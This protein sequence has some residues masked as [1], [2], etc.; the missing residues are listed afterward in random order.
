M[1]FTRV[2]ILIAVVALAADA[3]ATDDL[4]QNGNFESRDASRPELPAHWTEHHHQQR[5]LTFTDQ[6]YSPAA[7][8][9][10]VGDGTAQMWRQDVVK[11]PVRSFTLSGVVKAEDVIIGKDDYAH[12][13]AHII[14]EGRPYSDATHFFVETP[15]GT[16]D[17]KTISVAGAANHDWPIDRIHISVQGK[18]TRGRIA[19]DDVKLTPNRSLSPEGLLT[20]KLA[21]LKAQLAR[22]GGVDSSVA[23][24]QAEVEK[25]LALLIGDTP[26][27]A[28]AR[29]HWIRAAEAV[30]PAAWAAVYPDAMTER[31]VEARMMYHG[32][33]STPEGCDAYLDLIEKTGCNAAYLSLGSW[34]YVNYPSEVF[35]T[36]PGYDTFDALAYF[37]REAH[38]RGIKVFAYHAPFYG[39][40]DPVRLPGNAFDA[41]PEWFAGGPERNLPYFPDP[42]NP[43]TVDFIVSAY[44][45]LARRYD[46]DGVGLDY[47]RYP[48]PKSLGFNELNRREIQER[49]GFDI[50]AEEDIYADAEKWRNIQAYRAEKVGHVVRRVTEAVR[51]VKPNMWV[52]ASLISEAEMA[53]DDYGQNWLAAAHLL[54]YASPMNYDDRSI[55]EPMLRQQKSVYDSHRTVY[56]PAIG[57]MP[58]VHSSWTISEWA[59]RVALQRQIGAD[60]IVIY[61]IGDFD[62]AVAAFFGNGPFHHPATFPE[63][64]RSR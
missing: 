37:I 25:G 10:I 54:D 56:L 14:Y 36:E 59:K 7:G 45:E 17:W 55:N 27:V 33:T 2:L 48:T 58:D 12:L 35:P 51:A 3:S 46:L 47:I 6:H 32:H 41:H 29:T 34:M 50:L 52:I 24:S 40:S 31:P 30:S 22:V 21:D 5:P 57:G 62:P 4:I 18:F 15:S 49:F 13:Y 44:V 16:Y 61:R 20:G 53:R 11:P 63:S 8:G 23:T 1:N 28:A 38:Q 19:I 60:G 64:R 9:L 26:D 42:A 43:Q 39:T